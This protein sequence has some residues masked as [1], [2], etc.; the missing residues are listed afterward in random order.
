MGL[1]TLLLWIWMLSL[2]GKCGSQA[3][4]ITYSQDP[5]QI[6]SHLYELSKPV[7]C[8]E[9]AGRCIYVPHRGLQLLHG[10]WIPACNLSEW[11]PW[12]CWKA[13]AQQDPAFKALAVRIGEE[14]TGVQTGE[15][16]GG[17]ARDGV[18]SSPSPFTRARGNED[19]WLQTLV[20]QQDKVK[21]LSLCPQLLVSTW[22]TQLGLFC[23][24]LP[25]AQLTQCLHYQYYVPSFL[26][27]N[28][29]CL[30]AQDAW[31]V[32]RCGYP[33]TAIEGTLPYPTQTWEG[34]HWKNENR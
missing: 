24:L 28:T 9:W 19:L 29:E 25:R 27:V 32:M 18:Q 11:W 15:M 33:S 23:L 7:S 10:N 8:Y 12:C 13:D 6:I 17:H 34:Y 26:V 30:T 14:E 3:S 21:P 2:I 5:M 22:E 4:V 31:V 16:K 1:F 20:S